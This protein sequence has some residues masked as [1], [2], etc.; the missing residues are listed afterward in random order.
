MRDLCD[1][2]GAVYVLVNMPEHPERFAAQHGPATHR[3]YHER[4]RAWAAEHGVPFLDVTEADLAAFAKDKWY[5]D[6]HHM[7][8]A[9]AARFS[10]LLASGSWNGRARSSCRQRRSR[11]RIALRNVNGR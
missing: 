7:S 2:A 3:D 10:T 5:S 11:Q 9:G 8:P 4:I 1:A 6:F